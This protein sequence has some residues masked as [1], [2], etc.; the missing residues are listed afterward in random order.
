MSSV[1][2]T[3][4][5]RKSG[6]TKPRDLQFPSRSTTIL[7]YAPTEQLLFDWQRLTC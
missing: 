7:Y 5:D 1:N 2:A 6:G 4:F 3:N